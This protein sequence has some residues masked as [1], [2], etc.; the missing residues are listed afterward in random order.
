MLPGIGCTA[1]GGG[2]DGGGGGG[3]C[4]KGG[5]GGLG[6]GGGGGGGGGGGLG[7]GGGGGLLG[8]GG[9]RTAGG[10]AGPWVKAPDLNSLMPASACIV[11]HTT[12][13]SGMLRGV[14]PHVPSQSLLNLR[15]V[16]ERL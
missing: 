14:T 15:S 7:D 11:V 4:G 8:G 1:N 6:E 16:G 13:G 2:G 12:P 10:G 9:D 3:G 5:G